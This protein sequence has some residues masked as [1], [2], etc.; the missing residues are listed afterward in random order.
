MNE[1]QCYQCGWKTDNHEKSLHHVETVHKVVLN[2]GNG[3]EVIC[4]ELCSFSADSMA[5][6]R[7]HIIEL[8]RKEEWNWMTED[9]RIRFNCNECE[10]NFVSKTILNEHVE[11]DHQ[12]AR[13][14]TEKKLDQQEEMHEVKITTQ[15]VC[16]FCD[17]LFPNNKQRCAHMTFV[18]TQRSKDI[19][20]WFCD[21]ICSGKKDLCDHIGLKHSDAY[22]KEEPNQTDLDTEE[23][24][25]DAEIEVKEEKQTNYICNS[26]DDG[27]SFGSKRKDFAQATL[28]VQKLFHTNK[29]YEL[30]GV[31]FS[32]VK[33][34]KRKLC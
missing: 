23:G 7:V 19:P 13:Y 20:C 29:E 5:K 18:H 4:C 16:D 3:T 27:F 30:D 14:T 1:Y 25:I 12:E 34:N 24:K 6:V 33:R 31:K 22:I 21:E 32:L 15:F 9:I 2:V 11:R 26:W 10:K 8:H 17:K 28:E